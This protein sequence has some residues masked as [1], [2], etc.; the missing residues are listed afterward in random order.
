MEAELA[1]SLE[2]KQDDEEV[3]QAAL[4]LKATVAYPMNYEQIPVPKI[5]HTLLSKCMPEAILTR[6]KVAT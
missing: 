6:S 4:D 2:L 1:P 5:E 3:L